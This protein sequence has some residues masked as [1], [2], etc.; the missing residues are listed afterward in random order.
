MLTGG[1]QLGSLQKEED[2]GNSLNHTCLQ[3]AYTRV[4][5]SLQS[6]QPVYRKGALSQGRW[7]YYDGGN[8]RWLVD[9][10]LDSDAAFA[11]G[12]AA[13]SSVPPNAGWLQYCGSGG[14]DEST[15]RVLCQ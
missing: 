14:Y 13:A 7:V 9:Q 2:R 6:G 1:C 10:D 12:S 8:Q 11:L 3:G 15:L 4:P 5:N